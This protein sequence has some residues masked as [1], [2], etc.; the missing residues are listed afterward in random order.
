MTPPNLQWIRKIGLV[1]YSKARWV[2]AQLPDP[3]TGSRL[4]QVTTNANEGLDL[5]EMRIQFRIS[6]SDT[7]TPNTAIIRV[8]NLSP[9]TARKVQGEFQ[10][11]V[12]QAG[13]ENASYG[14]IFD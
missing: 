1:V 10:R 4:R 14:V 3:A 11:V 8:Y 7:E 9:E 13:Y 5:S 6:Q 12:L 2:E